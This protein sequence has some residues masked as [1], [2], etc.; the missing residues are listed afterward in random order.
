VK[1]ELPSLNGRAWRAAL[2]STRQ[3]L[4]HNGPRKIVVADAEYITVACPRGKRL[5]QKTLPKSA[6]GGIEIIGVFWPLWPC[7]YTVVI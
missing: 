4:R 6:E 7:Q 2:S 3:A 5:Y 1:I